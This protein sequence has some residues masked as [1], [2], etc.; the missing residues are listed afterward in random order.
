M[1][2]RGKQP[3]QARDAVV[4]ASHDHDTRVVLLERAHIHCVREAAQ[5]HQ[6]HHPH[7]VLVL[8]YGAP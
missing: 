4:H 1:E 5:I 3:T 8:H 2:R 6:Q 7:A